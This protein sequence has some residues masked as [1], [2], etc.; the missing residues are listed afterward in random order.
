MWN[1]VVAKY[2]SN[3]RVYFDPMNEP[4]GYSATDWMNIAA[5]WIADRPNVPKNRIIVSGVGYDWDVKPL[6]ADS[7]FDGTY[8]AYHH[9]A[10]DDP[11][12]TTYQDWVNQ[13]MG[14]IGTC[15]SRTIL[16]EFGATMDSGANYDDPNSTNAEV[17]YLRAYTDTVRSLNMGAVYWAGIGGRDMAAENVSDYDT[18]DVQRLFSSSANVPLRTP[19]TT[20]L[21]RLRYAWGIASGSP[22]T[23]L[24]NAADGNCL[25]VPGAT[26]DN[27]QVQ[28]WQCNGGANQNWTRTAAGQITVY[29]G[30]KCLDAYDNGTTD[31]TP[32][33]TWSCNGGAIQQ[34]TFFTDGTIRGV[35]SGL[36]LDVNMATSQLELWDCHGGTNQQWKTV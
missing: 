19:N 23:T 4:W 32:V 31:G 25:D 30:E 10:G 35:Q 27:V 17:Q 6:C 11:Q 2:L 14:D 7:R 33:G 20:G 29:N 26:H 21:D 5:G 36:C 22:T 34:W 15:A 24:Q 3:P 8:L 1:T 12:N 16:E 18:F 28:T 13:F 9:Y